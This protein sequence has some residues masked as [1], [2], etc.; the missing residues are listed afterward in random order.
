M[1]TREDAARPEEGPRA[2]RCAGERPDGP[3]S[4]AFRATGESIVVTV[5]D[6]GV[7][8][9]PLKHPEPDLTVPV[10][11]RPAG[12]MGVYLIKQLMDEV[13]Y[14]MDDGRNVLTLTKRI[15]RATCH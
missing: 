7:G 13:D 3:I 6:A 4:V 15:R 11:A 1:R 12:G 8:F 9:D 5:E 14:R 10:E 2:A